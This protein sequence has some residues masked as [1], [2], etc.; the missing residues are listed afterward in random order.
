MSVDF[1]TLEP[2]A[3]EGSDSL[4]LVR[5]RLLLALAAMALVPAALLATAMTA[6]AARAAERDRIARDSAYVSATVAGQLGALRE[7]LLLVAADPA[8][9]GT[10]ERSTPAVREGAQSS[11]AR[12]VSLAGAR[13]AALA[14]VDRSD[15]EVVRVG[16][17]ASGSPSPSE[18]TAG[19]DRLAARSQDVAVG[20]VLASA[21]FPAEGGDWHL[22][23]DAPVENSQGTVVGT[24]RA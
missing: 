22:M 17:V 5:L 9:G 18:P 13:I 8:L 15:H 4:R 10:I 11:L 20:T 16:D 7:Q 1:K 14:V 21:P 2:I 24:V 19:A 6:G 12:F 23:L 3:A